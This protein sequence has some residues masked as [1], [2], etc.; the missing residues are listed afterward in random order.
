MMKREAHSP[1]A[2]VPLV[3]WALVDLRASGPQRMGKAFCFNF[4]V[5]KPFWNMGGSQLTNTWLTGDLE[6]TITARAR[7]ATGTRGRFP[8]SSVWRFGNMWVR[9]RKKGWDLLYKPDS[10]AKR[11]LLAQSFL[12]RNERKCGRRKQGLLCKNEK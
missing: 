8:V 6:L 2:P 7:V 4:S 12:G 3:V 1:S 10:R 11:F 5:F 9:R